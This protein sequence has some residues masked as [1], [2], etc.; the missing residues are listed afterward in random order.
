MREEI[1]VNVTPREVRAALLENGVLQEVLIERASRRGLI[2]NIYKGRVSRVLPGMQA[3]FIDIGI[4]RTAFLH[5]SDIAHN[6][7]NGDGGDEVETN[8]RDLVQEGDELL[9][10]VLK[11]PL[12]RGRYMLELRGHLLDEQS[13]SHQDPEFLM[14]QMELRESLEEIRDQD[15]PMAALDALS[16]RVRDQYKALESALSAVLDEGGETD[17]AVTLVLRMQY[18]T[19]LQ[20]ELQALEA[21]LEDELY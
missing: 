18:F 1:L 17:Q 10:Q 8:I 21:D 5:A 19:R 12:R 20:D 6:P 4:E 11:D 9:V 16:R 2:S 7:H 13:G 14:Q 15:D 3:A